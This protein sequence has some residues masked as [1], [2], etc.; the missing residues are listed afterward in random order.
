MSHYW[1]VFPNNFVH[2]LMDIL[3]LVLRQAEVQREA[4]LGFMLRRLSHLPASYDQL[5]LVL[6]EASLNPDS[7]EVRGTLVT[8]GRL[9]KVVETVSGCCSSR[10]P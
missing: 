6:E 1:I 10:F 2:Q 4:I 8:G 7:T 5:C 9:Y 3:S